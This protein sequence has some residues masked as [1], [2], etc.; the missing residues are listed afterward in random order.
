MPN[1]TSNLL[2][3]LAIVPLM[4]PFLLEPLA[5]QLKFNESAAGQP[6]ESSWIS[7]TEI[8]EA[9]PP[10]EMLPPTLS[11]RQSPF[12]SSTKSTPSKS[13]RTAVNL[14]L[15][16]PKVSEHQGNQNT[17]FAPTF[18]SNYA[19]SSWGVNQSDD[20]EYFAH[21]MP[22]VGGLAVRVLKESKAHPHVTR[23]I[24]AIHPEF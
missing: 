5:A 11:N 1:G 20:L 18:A 10:A 3:V 13:Y 24:Q 22:L 2:R 23:V 14:N 15:L 8:A 9:I 19:T 12:H 4:I 17:S 21:H 16:F 7:T 6:T